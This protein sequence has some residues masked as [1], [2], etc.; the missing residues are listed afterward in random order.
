LIYGDAP[1]NVERN[2][3]GRN[4]LLY[5]S[6]VLSHLSNESTLINNIYFKLIGIEEPEAHLHP[7]LQ[8]HLTKNIK[9][10]SKHF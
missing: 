4:N 10:E 1:V 3:L 7:N 2:G 9:R 8:E 6:L 5:I